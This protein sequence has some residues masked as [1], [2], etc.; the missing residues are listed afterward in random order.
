MLA[1][2]SSLQNL[3]GENIYKVKL[4]ISKKPPNRMT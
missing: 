3:R 4:C 1:I 2:D